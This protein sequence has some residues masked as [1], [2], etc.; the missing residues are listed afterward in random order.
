MAIHLAGKHAT[1]EPA[2]HSGHSVNWLCSPLFND[3]RL[4]NMYKIMCLHIGR[5]ADG[6]CQRREQCKRRYRVAEKTGE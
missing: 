4:L 5:I 6:L 3:V 2:G 1:R